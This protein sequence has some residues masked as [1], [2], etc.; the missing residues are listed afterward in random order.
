MYYLGYLVSHWILQKQKNSQE[1]VNSPPRIFYTQE[2]QGQFRIHSQGAQ[3]HRTQMLLTNISNTALTKTHST[4]S[5][6]RL[7]GPYREQLVLG[8]RSAPRGLLKETLST[9]QH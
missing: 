6:V 4:T 2:I 3:M 7:E 1:I 5:F 9:Y 8:A